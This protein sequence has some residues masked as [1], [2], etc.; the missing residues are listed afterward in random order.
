MHSREIELFSLVKN[1]P[2]SAHG[3]FE[4][5]NMAKMQLVISRFSILESGFEYDIPRDPTPQNLR[6]RNLPFSNICPAGFQRTPIYP[7]IP[8]ERHDASSRVSPNNSHSNNPQRQSKD[9][10]HGL[11]ELRQAREGLVPSFP[12]GR[13]MFPGARA[14]EIDRQTKLGA[15]DPFVYLLGRAREL[16][17]VNKPKYRCLL[18]S[19]DRAR[20]TRGSGSWKCISAAVG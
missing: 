11:Q 6:P 13:H 15:D 17:P 12:T 7:S 8:I 9:R 19:R 10:R 2:I 3:M 20:C 18:A 14:R 1:N 4:Y 5:Q 16:N